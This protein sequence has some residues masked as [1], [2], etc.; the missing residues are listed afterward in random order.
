MHEKWMAE[1]RRVQRAGDKLVLSPVTDLDNGK[2]VAYEM[3]RRPVFKLVSHMLDKPLATLAKE[4]GPILHSDQ[5][6]QHQMPEWSR[7]VASRNIV[8]SML[9]K[10]SCLDTVSLVR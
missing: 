10:G 8:P 1:G 5:G 7:M 9:R 2:I 3:A 4:D 6:C